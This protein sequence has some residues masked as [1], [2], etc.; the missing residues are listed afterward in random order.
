MV[1]KIKQVLTHFSPVTG[2]YS[3]EGSPYWLKSVEFS[4]SVIIC[5]TT[6]KER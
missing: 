5:C 3:L 1:P 2:L 4:V 6:L